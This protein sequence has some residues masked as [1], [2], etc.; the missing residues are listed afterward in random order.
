MAVPNIFKGLKDA[1]PRVDGNYLTEGRYWLRINKLKID[2]SRKNES[3]LAIEMTNIR[4]LDDNQGKGHKPGEDVTHMLMAKFDSFLGNVK[5]FAV[6]ALGGQVKPEEVDEAGMMELCADNQPLHG[7]VVEVNNKGITTRK[8]APFTTVNYLRVVGVEELLHSL[9][10][11]DQD[12]Y[13]PDNYLQKM[14]AQ[15]QQQAKAA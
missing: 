13:F 8:G 11:A 5:Q 9:S 12:R 7:L 14:L 15:E 3:F 2:T 1:K 10:K 6:C 4:T